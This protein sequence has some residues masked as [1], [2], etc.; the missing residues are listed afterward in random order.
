M[1]AAQRTKRGNRLLQFEQDNAEV[2]G[3]I[4][5][6]GIQSDGLLKLRTG[7][8]KLFQ[9]QIS[10][11]QIVVRR[12]GTR[13]Q[14]ESLLVMLDRLRHLSAL[15]L[16]EPQQKVCIRALRIDSDGGVQFFDRTGRIVRFKGGLGSIQVRLG[17]SASWPW[18]LRPS[19]R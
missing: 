16:R 5:L 11:S 10:E 8:P 9:L 1:S 17:L 14:L 7:E 4:G 12:V 19:Q 13:V 15:K 6:F 2:I 18:L 3:G